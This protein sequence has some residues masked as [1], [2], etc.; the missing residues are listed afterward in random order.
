MRNCSNCDAE[1]RK[2]AT[3]CP[4][5][6]V[7]A[8]EFVDGQVKNKERDKR[9]PSIHLIVLLILAIGAAGYGVWMNR[10]REEPAEAPKPVAPPV[11]VVKDRPGGNVTE[12]A[13]IRILVAHL[14]ETRGVKRECVVVMSKGFH[15]HAYELSAFN[16]CEKTRLG[17]FRVTRSGE[18]K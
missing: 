13:A 18:V 11:R 6:G 16:H 12:A 15:D 17:T 9:P 10:F 4:E 14:V 8:G 5:C 7:F 3:S 2:D 1:L